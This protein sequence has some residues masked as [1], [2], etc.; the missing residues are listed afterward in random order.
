MS[1]LKVN[2]IQ[3]TSGGSTITNVGKVIQV[4]QVVKTDTLSVSSVGS[5]SFTNTDSTFNISITPSSSSNLI[6]LGGFVNVAVSGG[7][8]GVKMIIR[9]DGSNLTTAVN[10]SGTA[11]AVG[12]LD[13]SR[14]RATSGGAIA[15][16]GQHSIPISIIDKPST[17]NAVT[18]SLGL[19]HAS[20][21]SR[22]MY[23]NLVNADA[24][25]S[26][27]SRFCSVFIA[28]EISA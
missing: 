5:G 15:N 21:V 18:Y 23:I 25:A 27:W 12:D 10:G 24:N 8:Q 17:T 4:I 28:Q 22:T 1:T 13:G 26:Q 16:H 6:L 11:A 7:D 14:T 20:S 2:E 9:R 19:G 3:N